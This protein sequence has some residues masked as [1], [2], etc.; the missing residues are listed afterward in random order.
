MSKLI[1]SVFSSVNS[2]PKT[3]W[4]D[5]NCCNNI[6]YSPHFLEAFEKANTTIDFNYVFIL[7]ETKAVAFAYTQ[8]VTIGIET[9]TKN[10]KISDGFKDKINRFFN[11]NSPR[12]LFCGNIFLSGE[13]GTFLKTG[14]DK[15]RLFGAIADALKVITKNTEKL[16][17]VFIK[18]F[19]TESLD[20]TKQLECCDYIPMVVEPNMIISLQPEWHSFSDYK[21]ALKSKYRIKANKADSTSE[22]LEAKLLSS[23]DIELYKD[24]LQA[25]YENTIANA[26]FNAQ[27]LDLNTYIYLKSYY[28]KE[29]IVK[30]YFLNDTLVGF[31]SAMV[32]QEHLD[33]HFIGI[34]YSLNKQYAIYPRIL[35]DYV[36]LGIEHQV[37]QINLGRTASEI[38][39]TLGAQPEALTCYLKHKKIVQNQVLKP[40]I[41][42]VKIKT[43]KQ[44]QPFKEPKKEA[45]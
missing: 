45:I 32:N 1:T 20:I 36:R 33:A 22:I 28:D 43:F 30:G 13:Y 42:N 7:K 9:I 15:H 16:S 29:F 19:K 44:H 40:F 6:Y 25:L 4:E 27:I 34:D 2:I 8:F 24:Q 10:I 14:E 18:D 39:S 38:K 37:S 11:A 23:K 35:N 12:I 31:L 41:R 26:N 5:L 17:A 21:N 3:Y